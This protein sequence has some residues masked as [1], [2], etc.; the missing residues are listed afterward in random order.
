MWRPH[1]TRRLLKLSWQAAATLWIV[2]TL[3]SPGPIGC[4]DTMGY[5]DTTGCGDIMCCGDRRPLPTLWGA[6]VSLDPQRGAGISRPRRRGGQPRAWGSPGR[7]PPTPT[8]TPHRPL[9]LRQVP[10]VETRDR[11]RL[12]LAGSNARSREFSESYVRPQGACVRV[13]VRACMC[14]YGGV[15]R[16]CALRCDSPANTPRP[17]CCRD[18]G[19]SNLGV[20]PSQ[21][22][23]PEVPNQGLATPWRCPQDVCV[24]VYHPCP[25]HRFV[26]FLATHARFS[27]DAC[28]PGSSLVRLSDRS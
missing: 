8:S 26:L 5:G 13:C 27:C 15:R 1:A 28:R 25:W 2:A 20:S 10:G 3:R 14:V 19:L 4:G 22:G 11:E 7:P 17:C 21:S 12:L 18:H 9:P 23:V 6:A 16:D 24:C